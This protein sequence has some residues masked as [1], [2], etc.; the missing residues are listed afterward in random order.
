[1]TPDLTD[2][3]RKVLHEANDAGP[4]TVVDPTT[5][6]EYV[7][8]RADVFK[9]MGEWVRDLE[10]QDAYPVVDRVMADDDAADPSLATYQD[11]ALPPERA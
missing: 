2:Q 4:V 7:L 6:I 3:Q 9:E 5:N 1:M 10:P 8:V 11:D